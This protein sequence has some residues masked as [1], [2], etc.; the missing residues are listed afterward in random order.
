M[1]SKEII[2]KEIDN[3]PKDRL[4]ELHRLIKDFSRSKNAQE[5]R[6]LMIKLRQIKI[7]GPKDFAK[8]IDTYLSGEIGG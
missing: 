8:N 6:N 7:H 1:V 5:K 3:I 2:I 4:F